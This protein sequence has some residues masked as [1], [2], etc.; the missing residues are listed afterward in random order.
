MAFMLTRIDVRDYDAWKQQFDQDQP[1]ARADS[2]GWRVMRNVDKPD[3]VFIQVEF[4]STD[5]AKTARERLLAS[6]VLD[7]F[8]DKTGPTVVEEAELV[9]R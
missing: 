7:R 4:A 5:E 9:E 8:D 2:K 6:G 1:R 3:E